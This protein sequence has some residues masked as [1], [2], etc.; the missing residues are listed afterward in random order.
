MSQSLCGTSASLTSVHSSGSSLVVLTGSWSCD[1]REV[2]VLPSAASVWNGCL[3]HL[4]LFFANGKR[5]QNMQ[6]TF[7]AVII[8]QSIR[9]TNRRCSASWKCDIG[10]R[11]GRSRR[12]LRQSVVSAREK[13]KCKSDLKWKV[14]FTCGPLNDSTVPRWTAE[15]NYSGERAVFFFFCEAL[16]DQRSSGR[17]CHSAFGSPW[18]HVREAA[19]SPN[20]ESRST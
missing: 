10:V 13:D 14:S 3:A 16:S 17:T 2:E 5:R 9:R 18:L 4:P 7:S 20:P 15:A 11:G 1:H 19:P 8:K 6:V 12:E